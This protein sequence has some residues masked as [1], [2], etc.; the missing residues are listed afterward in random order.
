MLPPVSIE[1]GTADSILVLEFLF[2]VLNSLMPIL[3][4]KNSTAMKR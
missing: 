1:P 3:D 4:A 2:H